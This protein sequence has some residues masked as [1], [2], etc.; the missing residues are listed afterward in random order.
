M[1]LM[2]TINDLIRSAREADGIRIVVADCVDGISVYGLKQH[3]DRF[4][5]AKRTNV[6]IENVIAEIGSVRDEIAG[7]WWCTYADAVLGRRA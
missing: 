1:T 3:E 4:F 7:E 2:E 6:T 5:V